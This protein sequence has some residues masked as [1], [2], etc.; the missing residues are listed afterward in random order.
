MTLR[1]FYAPTETHKKK[2]LPFWAIFGHFW[3]ISWVFM[4]FKGNRIDNVAYFCEEKVFF[5]KN[6]K[7]CQTIRE[8]SKNIFWGPGNLLGT[9]KSLSRKDKY[10]QI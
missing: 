10:G 3:Y 1:D 9:Q 4:L 7:F 6:F 5:H 2:F 8:L